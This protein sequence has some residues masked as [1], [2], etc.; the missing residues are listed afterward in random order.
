METSPARYRHCIITVGVNFSALAAVA[1]LGGGLRVWRVGALSYATSLLLRR[2][3]LG[4]K[5]A[6]TEEWLRF[7]PQWLRIFLLPD[8]ALNTAIR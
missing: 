7:P 5:S 8:G 4:V 1:C 6:S 3:H 2:Y